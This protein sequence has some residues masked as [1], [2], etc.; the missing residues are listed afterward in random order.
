M[1]D[2][3]KEMSSALQEGMLRIVARDARQRGIN[4]TDAGRLFGSNQVYGGGN[5]NTTQNFFTTGYDS[6]T[7]HT[8]VAF[9]VGFSLVDGSDILTG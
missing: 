5:G 2:I 7:G 4:A 8:T 6:G 9:L 1:P 3:L